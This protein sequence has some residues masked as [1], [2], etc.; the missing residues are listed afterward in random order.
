MHHNLPSAG[1]TGRWKTCKLVSRNYWWPNLTIDVKRYV[2]GC[3]I[4]QH[5]KNR[6]Q[7]SYG[8]LMS[9][10]ISNEP[11]EIISMN[12]ITQLPESNGYTAICVIV[13]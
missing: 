3:D 5:M 8:P 7:K 1:H 12:F 11:W 2:K 4:C 13:C 10:P 6:P 9:N